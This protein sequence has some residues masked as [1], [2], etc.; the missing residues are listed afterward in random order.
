M[1]ASPLT[2][3]RKSTNP[4]NL[5]RTSLRS[6]TSL[7]AFG[8]ERFPDHIMYDYYMMMLEWRVP[9]TERV[10]PGE[11]CSDYAGNPDLINAP[12]CPCGLR[13]VEHRDPSIKITLDQHLLAID[14]MANRNWGQ[15]AQHS[16]I[17]TEIRGQVTAVVGGVDPHFFRQMGQD[18]LSLLGSML[19]GRAPATLPPPDA[20]D[21]EFV[22]HPSGPEDGEVDVEPH[23]EPTDPEPA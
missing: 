5:D 11:H 7:A 13:V 21:V 3:K 15:P 1:A 14:R 17:E 4:T 22:D 10:P 20:Q 18:A 8:R 16:H 12:D 19:T 9:K 6:R 2:G 23:D